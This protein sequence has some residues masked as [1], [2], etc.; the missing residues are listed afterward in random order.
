MYI[1]L[2]MGE[3]MSEI[4]SFRTKSCFFG[5]FKQLVLLGLISIVSIFSPSL[6]STEGNYTG[7]NPSLAQIDANWRA[8]YGTP[9][10]DAI[11]VFNKMSGGTS[12]DVS[13]DSLCIMRFGMAGSTTATMKNLMKYAQWNGGTSADWGVSS[14]YRISKDGAKI[15]MQ[16]GSGVSVCD[17]TGLNTKI[18]WT[19]SLNKDQ[20]NMSWDDTVGIRRI[21]YSIGFIIVRTVI[22]SDNTKGK[23]DTLWSHS[24]KDPSSGNTASVYTSVNKVGNFLCFDMPAGVNVPVV[25]NL[26]T[27]TTAS[28]TNGEDG[29]QVRMLQDGLGTVSFHPSTHLTSTNVWRWGMKEDV[30]TTLMKIP[31]PNGQA[32]NCSDCGNNMFYWCDSDTNYMVQTG[33]NQASVSPGCYSKAFIRKGKNSANIK[34]LGDYIAFPALWIN[35]NVPTQTFSNRVTTSPDAKVTVKLTKTELTL[36]NNNNR[37]I[38]NAILTNVNGA[39]VATGKKVTPDIQQFSVLGI[40]AGTYILSWHSANVSSARFITIAW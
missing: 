19:G 24:S 29:C 6:A 15:A 2:K 1:N 39:V 23:T 10:H 14:T 30:N 12:G 34:Y 21:V 22:N 3:S 13:K 9:V 20:L 36:V 26:A 31:C 35:P 32:S 27:K 33:D 11:L 7:T 40:P 5:I 25:V 8:M 17:T 4:I 38:D 28:P 37:I 16:N 18:I